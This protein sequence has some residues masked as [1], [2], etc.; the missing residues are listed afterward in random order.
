MDDGL[1]MKS[2]IR[3][4]IDILTAE[5]QR[6]TARLTEI[7]HEKTLLQAQKQANTIIL[8]GIQ[9]DLLRLEA[10]KTQKSA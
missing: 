10:Q 1:I 8:A 4:K 5:T 6:I 7:E 9:R 2:R 3:R